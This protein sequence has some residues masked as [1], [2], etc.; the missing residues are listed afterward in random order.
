LEK[1]VRFYFITGT[2]LTPIAYFATAFIVWIKSPVTAAAT[3]SPDRLEYFL[4]IGI[5][6]AITV[7]GYFLNA[8]YIN[9]LYGRHIKNLKNLL[10]EIEEKEPFLNS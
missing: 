4:L 6:L 3:R 5:G 10:S 9:K 7:A 8:W 1:Y 2:I